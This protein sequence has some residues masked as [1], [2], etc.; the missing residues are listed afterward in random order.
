[1]WRK[2]RRKKKEKEKADFFFT[3]FHTESS[4]STCS[5]FCTPKWKYFLLFAKLNHLDK[6]KKVE[7]PP[8]G[9]YKMTPLFTLIPGNSLNQ[10]VVN[11][12]FNKLKLKLHNELNCTELEKTMSSLW[13][14]IFSLFYYSL[15]RSWKILLSLHN[16]VGFNESNLYMIFLHLIN[17]FMIGTKIFIHR[18]LKV[19]K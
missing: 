5:I 14:L 3:F 2:L 6:L 11:F 17:L 19:K 13:C 15:E 8:P 18:Y 1:M 4:G 12:N 7:Y 10:K 16:L 9:F